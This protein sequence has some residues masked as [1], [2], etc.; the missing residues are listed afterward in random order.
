MPHPMPLSVLVLLCVALIA[1]LDA[2]YWL[3][4]C[5]VLGVRGARA[6]VIALVVLVAA[7]VLTAWL[8]VGAGWISVVWLA[9]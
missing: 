8:A 9:L 5:W 2:C 1:F 4:R 7:L 6:A 3:Y